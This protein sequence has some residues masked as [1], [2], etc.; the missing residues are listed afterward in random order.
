MNLVSER[1]FYRLGAPGLSVDF[2]K[3]KVRGNL[4]L[5]DDDG[6]VSYCPVYSIEDILKGVRNES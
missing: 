2:S 1:N 4:M 3:I 6:N 5:V